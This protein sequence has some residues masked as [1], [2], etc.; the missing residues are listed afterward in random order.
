MNLTEAN[1]LVELLGRQTKIEL[2]RRGKMETVL[3]P[4]SLYENLAAIEI[5][6]RYPDIVQAITQVASPEDIARNCRR[7]GGEFITMPVWTVGFEFLWGRQLLLTLGEIRPDQYTNEAL[8]V[9]EFWKRLNLAFRR[10]GFVC[11]GQAG[12]VNP[13]LTK[14]EVAS[15]Y[16]QTSPIEG[17]S[18]ELLRRLHAKALA[19]L[20]LMNCE[21]RAKYCDSGPYTID[22]RR[23]MLFSDLVDITGSNYPWGIPGLLPFNDLSMA[24]VLSDVKIR[25]AN[26]G[27]AYGKPANFIQN[28]VR[29]AVFSNENGQLNRIESEAWAGLLAG[30]NTAQIQLYRKFVKMSIHERVIAG[31]STY[32]WFIRPITRFVGIDDKLDWKLAHLDRFYERLA[33]PGVADDLF[34][35]ALIHPLEI[36]SSYTPLA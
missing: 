22:S 6:F 14:E 15:F 26:A 4:N 12:Y 13:L 10:D 30:L 1:E 36:P 24:V 31:T 7:Y 19:L 25:I 32:F 35:R 9:L 3:F 34:D 28:A 8:R 16:D 33:G 23:V 21:S 11:N 27:L 20:I 18:A 5:F 2:S 29:A 17:E